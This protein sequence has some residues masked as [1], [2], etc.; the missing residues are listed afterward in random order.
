MIAHKCERCGASNVQPLGVCRVCMRPVCSGC[1]SKQIGQ[2]GVL[3]THSDCFREN[4]H[5][6]QSSF[7][8]IKFRK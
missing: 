3:I 6:L 5:M 8:F 2:D 1:G 7:K 4:S